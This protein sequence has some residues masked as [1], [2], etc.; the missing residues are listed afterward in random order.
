MVALAI[1]H[2]TSS[3]PWRIDQ[4][5]VGRPAQPKRRAPSV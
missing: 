2:P 4:G 3:L 5:A 1:P